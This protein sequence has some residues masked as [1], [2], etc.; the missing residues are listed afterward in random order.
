MADGL[1][2]TAYRPVRISEG[3]I[4]VRGICK[5]GTMT[6]R[7]TIVALVL[8]AALLGIGCGGRTNLRITLRLTDTAY[9]ASRLRSDSARVQTRLDWLYEEP[10]FRPPSQRAK[11]E[12]GDNRL[13][14]TVED[15]SGAA[16]IEHL[17]SARGMITFNLI[18]DD[19]TEGAAL[20]SVESWLRSHPAPT[21]PVSLDKFIFCRNQQCRV[22]ERDYPSAR[23]ILNTVDTA[24]YAVWQPAFGMP[25]SGKID[26]S[27]IL[28]FVERQPE[29]TNARGW[30][31]EHADAHRPRG[32]RP[33]RPLPKDAEPFKAPFFVSIRLS[34]DTFSGT[35]PV[36]K[37]A[38]ISAAN[39]GRRLAMVI[40]S[41]VLSAPAIQDEIPDGMF[42]VATDDTIGAYSRDLTTILLNGPLHGRLVVER[43]ERVSGE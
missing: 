29:M 36:R 42:G 43:V 16:R 35:N 6:K 37:L 2:L 30:L 38:E 32:A 28:Y 17:A 40:D 41:V 10:G 25:D 31:I 20:D 7:R 22:L 23:S 27:R 11:V 34:S 39:V 33:S 12:V 9:S 26:T 1:R 8:L 18:A 3:R 14:V 24:V 19:S 13:V 21:G 15:T 5:W 4:D